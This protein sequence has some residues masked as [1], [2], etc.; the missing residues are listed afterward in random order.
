MAYSRRALL[1]L[2]LAAAPAAFASHSEAK[3]S[4]KQARKRAKETKTLANRESSDRKALAKQRDQDRQ[5]LNTSNAELDKARRQ[6]LVDLTRRRQAHITRVVMDAPAATGEPKPGI[7]PV[8]RGV[9]G[10]PDTKKK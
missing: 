6:D 10:A 5:A 1:S 2:L 3:R 8:T 4:A 7:K 9:E